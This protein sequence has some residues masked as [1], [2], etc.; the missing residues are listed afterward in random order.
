MAL[1]LKVIITIKEKII[2]AYIRSNKMIL[3]QS[4][5]IHSEYILHCHVRLGT[6]MECIYAT[7]LTRWPSRR[8]ESYPV[9]HVTI[10]NL[11]DV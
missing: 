10:D 9:S 5:S 2:S 3:C 8:C 1:N 4:F 7:V 6:L 11:L